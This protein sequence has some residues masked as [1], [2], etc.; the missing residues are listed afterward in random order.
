LLLARSS[1]FL[2][3]FIHFSPTTNWIYRTLQF[4]LLQS[5][6]DN[7]PM[8]QQEINCFASMLHCDTNQ[9]KTI[10]LLHGAKETHTIRQADI[11][12]ADVILFGGSGDYSV[13]QGG[14]WMPPV[15]SLMRKLVEQSKPTFA[16]CWGFQAMAKALGGEVI[17]D[18]AHAEIG[19]Q[20]VYLT[21]QGKRDPVFKRILETDP[22]QSF[23]A[24]MGHKDCVA[25]VPAC[26]VHLAYSQTVANQAFRVKDKPIYCTQFHPEL[27]RTA[28]IERLEAYPTYVEEIAG[29]PLAQFEDKCNHTPQANTILK[30]FVDSLV[31]K[32][33]S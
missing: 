28:L 6:D 17:T 15:M 11:D 20:P 10:S 22:S 26:A 5:R 13:A 32:S 21:E 7:D 29:I 16:S 27:D 8:R 9:L 31:L 3:T 25:K 19:T 4:L 2:K 24:V 18:T 33:H 1:K 14:L 23:D 30:H 12:N